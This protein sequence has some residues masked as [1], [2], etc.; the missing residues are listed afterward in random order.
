ML[1]WC[2]RPTTVDPS[3]RSMHLLSSAIAS[4]SPSA[5]PSARTQTRRHLPA[6]LDGVRESATAPAAAC[7]SGL[8]TAR[9]SRKTMASPQTSLPTKPISAPGRRATGTPRSV[10]LPSTETG[11]EPRA[12]SCAPPPVQLI[13]KAVRETQFC[14][15]TSGS[16]ALKSSG[17]CSL[18]TGAANAPVDC[19]ALPAGGASGRRRRSCGSESTSRPC[20]LTSSRQT[21]DCLAAGKY[22]TGT[23]LAL[24]PCA[25]PC[26][27]GDFPGVAALGC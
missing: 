15:L 22:S 2:C 12:T 25:A 1:D 13:S 24:R 16:Q 26:C 5:K 8:I 4:I 10:V 27:C 6:P 17:W 18:P 23:S 7:C 11:F 20:A 3:V 14:R 21:G 9:T 19:G